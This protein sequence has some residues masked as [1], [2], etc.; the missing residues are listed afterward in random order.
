MNTIQAPYCDILFHRHHV[1]QS[2]PRMSV[3]SRAAQFAPFAALTGYDDIINESA[4]YTED[5]PDLG[6]SL[7]ADLNDRLVFLLSRDRPPVA[8]VT[9]FAPD[10]KKSGGRYLTF[11]DR[12]AKYDPYRRRLLFASGLALPVESITDVASDE[13]DMLQF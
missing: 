13:L 2:R 11:T 3:H 7:K 1:S 4:R 10:A 5:S 9:Y 6:E 12:L 8:T